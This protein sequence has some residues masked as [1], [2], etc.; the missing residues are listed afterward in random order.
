MDVCG[1]FHGR[2][3]GPSVFWEKEWGS[4]SEETYRARIVPIVDGWLRLQADQEL[5]FMQDGASSH[6]A[7]GTIQDLLE[8]G[9][10]CIKWPA[11]SPDLNPIEYV[12]NKM[13]DWIQDRWDDTLHSYDAL[14]EA[15]TAAWEA[16]EEDYLEELLSTMEA[17]CQAVIDADGKQT[18]W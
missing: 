7:K 13:K 9:V 11:Y 2:T 3:K 12:W 16:V 18:S 5:V 8:R 15:I 6:S 10:I 4:I 14:R 17:R 1:C